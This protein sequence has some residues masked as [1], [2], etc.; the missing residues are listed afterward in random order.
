MQNRINPNRINIVTGHFGSG[1]TEV[2]VNMAIKL[3]KDGK[4]VTIVDLDIVNTYFRTEDA[5]QVLE[6]AGIRVI[7]PQFANTNLDMPTVPAEVISVFADTDSYV[8]FDIG[9]DKDG[10][11]ALG[12]YYRFFAKEPY[13]MYFVINTRRPLTQTAD[14][15]LEY[16]DE[17]QAASRLKITDLVNDTNLAA[18]TNIDVLLSGQ[19]AI[20][21][22]SEHTNIPLSFI[23][24]SHE[25]VAQLPEAL[26]DSAFGMDLYLKLDF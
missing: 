13:S 11:F 26:Q 9:G 22:V 2:A 23:C 14:D 1:K 4:K 6:Q 7:S 21:E 20:E 25:V 15:I 16:M 12:Q 18:D 17:I 19:S 5:R 24:G 8:V 3:A 10:A